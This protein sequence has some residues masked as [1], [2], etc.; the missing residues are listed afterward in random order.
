MKTHCVL[1]VNA[2]DV[3]EDGSPRPLMTSC[4]SFLLITSTRPPR[5]T[6]RLYNSN[7][8]NTCLAMIGNRLI[9]VPKIEIKYMVIFRGNILN[10]THGE[11]DG[12]N[13]KEFGCTYSASSQQPKTKTFW[14]NFQMCGRPFKF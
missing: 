2:A 13:I 9:G 10:I 11:K 6:T 5:A 1:S 4:Q 14:P 12:K 8:S 7:R 3:M